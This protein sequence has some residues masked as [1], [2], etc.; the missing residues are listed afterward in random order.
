MQLLLCRVNRR[1]V[2]EKKAQLRIATLS[3]FAAVHDQSLKTMRANAQEQFRNACSRNEQILKGIAGATVS[4]YEQLREHSDSKSSTAARLREE[5]RR[6]QKALASYQPLW[7]AQEL[8][9]EEQKLHMLRQEQEAAHQ[10]RQNWMA[11]ELRAETLK[12]SLDHERRELMIQLA[13]EEKDKIAADMRHSQAERSRLDVEQVLAQELTNYT[14]TAQ[15]TSAQLELQNEASNAEY[16]Q[17]SMTLQSNLPLAYGSP[18]LQLPVPAI[19]GPL[20]TERLKHHQLNQQGVSTNRNPKLG[21]GSSHSIA[22]ANMTSALGSQLHPDSFSSGFS[23]SSSIGSRVGVLSELAMLQGTGEVD[24]TNISVNS[25]NAPHLQEPVHSSAFPTAV[26]TNS[27]SRYISAASESEGKSADTDRENKEN[28][29]HSGNVYRNDSPPSSSVMPTALAVPVPI[30]LPVKS[31]SPTEQ[32]RVMQNQQQQVEDAKQ[33]PEQLGVKV[34]TLSSST[35]NP[36]SAL[37]SSTPL[38]RSPSMIHQSNSLSLDV[39][40]GGM[41]MTLHPSTRSPE[42]R[43]GTVAVASSNDMD[44]FSLSVPFSPQHHSSPSPS[45]GS[46]SPGNKFSFNEAADNKLATNV[47]DSVPKLVPTST[48]TLVVSDAPTSVNR[49][50]T[51]TSLTAQQLNDQSNVSLV[52][53]TPPA[54]TNDPSMVADPEESPM[55]HTRHTETWKLIQCAMSLKQLYSRFEELSS[56]RRSSELSTEEAEKRLYSRCANVLIGYNSDPNSSIT[57][58]YMQ[59]HVSVGRALNAAFNKRER[60]LVIYGPE[61]IV[62]AFLEIVQERAYDIM[63][64]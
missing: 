29:S 20:Q 48:S 15:Q 42:L 38:H 54:P 30:K 19:G 27:A 23:S 64:L 34:T 13:L 36:L 60:E 32:S 28:S 33:Q 26:S 2:L 58:E 16:I 14:A 1:H 39:D 10:R 37:S 63:P 12:K 22:V 47:A 21:A 46:K 3:E 59:S 5:K 4:S 17:R 45:K 41:G 9:L 49:P 51:P 31:E 11:E 40:A 44:E 52:P 6:Y 18:A 61:V 35:G 55:E 57:G 8:H 43:P 24:M 53:P 56:E 50:V 25:E 62:L 7:R